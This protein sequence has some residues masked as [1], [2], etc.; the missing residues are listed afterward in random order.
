MEDWPCSQAVLDDLSPEAPMLVLA[1]AV[2]LNAYSVDL[3]MFAPQG[4]RGI[5]SCLHSA[6]GSAGKPLGPRAPLGLHTVLSC[7]AFSCIS[8]M[9]VLL[10]HRHGCQQACLGSA[11]SC[12]PT[13][14]KSWR[15]P[16]KTFP[17]KY[18][19]RG[20]ASPQGPRLCLGR[21][22]LG[23]GKGCVCSF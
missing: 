19:R 1:G 9:N 7:L 11:T 4:R 3:S 21:R 6:A 18:L 10:Y 20:H 8:W 5:R 15:R 14:Q 23:S 22:R 2:S 13:E 12:R 16:G 17:S